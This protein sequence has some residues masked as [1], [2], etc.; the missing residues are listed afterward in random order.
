MGLTGALHHSRSTH[1]CTHGRSI[2]W[3]LLTAQP[4]DVA[5]HGHALGELVAV[6]LEDRHLSVRQAFP[7]KRARFTTREKTIFMWTQSHGM[8]R[9]SVGSGYKGGEVFAER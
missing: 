2:T 4:A 9:A 8:A 5:E 7:A 6:H 1:I 3:D